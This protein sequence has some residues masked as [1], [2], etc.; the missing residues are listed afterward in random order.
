MSGANRSANATVSAY[1]AAAI[2]ASDVTVI[3]VTRA[4]YVG[5][6]GNINVRMADSQATVLFSNVPVGIF[7]IQVDMVKSTSTTATTMVALY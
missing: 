5:V 6:S 4:I 1:D 3:P 7:P 2:T